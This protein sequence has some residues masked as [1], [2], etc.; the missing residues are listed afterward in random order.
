M[1]SKNCDESWQKINFILKDLLLGKTEVV[2]ELII[3]EQADETFLLFVQLCKMIVEV[4]E[5]SLQLARGNLSVALPSRK[6]FLSW[7]VKHLHAQLNHLVW[8]LKQVS[9]GDYTQVVDYMG[10]LAEGFNSLTEQLKLREEQSVYER[11]HDILTGLLNRDAF[12]RQTYDLIVENPNY[13][14]ALLYSNLENLKYIND[15][16]GYEVGD[17]YIIAAA[18]MFSSFKNIKG[19]VAR[20]SGDEF[21]VYV[22]GFSSRDT[23]RSDILSFIDRYCNKTIVTPDNNSHKIRSSIGLTWYPEDANNINDLIKYADYAMHEAKGKSKGSIIEFDSSAYLNK[24]FLFKKKEAINRLIDDNLIQ[25]AFQPIVDLHDGTIY[26]YEALMRSK[27]KEFASPMEILLVA[28]AQSKLYQIEKMTFQ[29]VLEWME[30]NRLI[31]EGK[32]IFIN[33]IAGQVLNKSDLG[34]LRN[35]YAHLYENIV[36][37]IMEGATEDRDLIN[38]K[39]ALISKEFGSLVA[40]DDYGSGQSNDFRLINL[41]PDIVKIDRD[42][43]ENIHLD[44]DR[45]MLLSKVVAFCHRKNIKILAEGVELSEELEVVLS[46]GFD[47]IQGYFFGRPDF[48]LKPLN[49]KAVNT[50]FELRETCFFQ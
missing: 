41:S 28:E 35:K 30:R 12:K 21:A 1:T 5:Y 19:V 8:Q 43:I 34:F 49:V 33:S 16:F 27:M 31:I 47:Y 15:S 7:S 46:L 20:I 9:K 44:L 17:R 32:K 13:F 42:F 4:N 25:F 24:R 22:H 40:I 39:K 6:N 38:N 14:G 11:D 36:F 48:E 29:G 45:Q 23:G 10:D 26:G 37:E 2:K 50:L 18:E 3:D